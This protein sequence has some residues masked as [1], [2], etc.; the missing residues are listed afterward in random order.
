MSEDLNRLRQLV[1][2]SVDAEPTPDPTPEE[3]ERLRRQLETNR[4]R[5]KAAGLDE[6]VKAVEA[7]LAELPEVQVVE[8]EVEEEAEDVGTGDYESR[9]LEQLRALAR[10]KNIAS[11]GTKD[12]VI[13]R[14]RG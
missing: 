6:D 13:T 14:L 10:S 12:E 8:V 1:E 2:V 3:A 4:D 7:R 5:F 9:T 11:S